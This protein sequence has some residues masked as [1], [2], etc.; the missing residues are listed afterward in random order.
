MAG[1][2]LELLFGT[3]RTCVACKLDGEQGLWKSRLPRLPPGAKRLTRAP[4]RGVKDGVSGPHMSVC[5]SVLFVVF[6][7]GILESVTE[8]MLR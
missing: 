2:A 6:V 3:K 1:E 7:W 8:G 4:M 5:D